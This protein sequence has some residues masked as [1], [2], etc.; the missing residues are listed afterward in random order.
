MNFFIHRLLIFLIFTSLFN[1]KNVGQT[2]NGQNLQKVKLQLKWKHAFQFA[3]YYAAIEKGYYKEAGLDVGLIEADKY[4]EPTKSV[5][6]GQAEFGIGMSD[7]I[8]H[9][10]RGFKPV[11]LASIFQHSPL[12]LITLKNSGIENIHQV[13]GKKLMIELQ[14]AELLAMMQYEGI[15]IKDIQQIKHSFSIQDLIDG[16]VDGMSAYITDEIYSLEKSGIQYNIISPLSSGID[17]YGD[18]LFTTEKMINENP[19]IVLKFTA[20]SLKGWKYALDNKSEIAGLIYSKYSKRL[21]VEH[22]LF[23]ADK[24][25][26]YILPNVVSIGYSN[27][28]RWQ[29]IIEVFNNLGLITNN[30]YVDGLLYDDYTKPKPPVST[31][32][33]IS[34]LITTIIVSLISLIFFRL[35]RKLKSEIKKSKEL[36]GQLKES[37]ELH[38]LLFQTS[39]ESIT[40]VQDNKI[41][42]FN[43]VFPELTGYPS[44]ELINM[45]YIDLIFAEDKQRLREYYER[46]LSGGT[47]P[48][49]YDFRIQQK[50][51]EIR[52]VTIQGANFQWYNKPANIYFLTDITDQKLTHLKLIEL[53][54]NLVRS[55]D[56]LEK[57]N[58]T[59]DKFFS[60]IAHDLRSPFQ[61]FIGLTELLTENLDLYSKDEIV[62]FIN[63]INSKANNLYRLLKN[64]LEWAGMQ[65]GYTEFKPIETDIK[66]IIQEIVTELSPSADK[67]QIVI[68]TNNLKYRKLSLDKNM[69]LSVFRNLISNAIKFTPRGGKVVISGNLEAGNF[70]EITVE[71]TGIGISENDLKKLFKIEEKIS[72]TGTDGEESTGLGLLLSKEFINKHNGSIFVKSILGKGSSFIV[73]LPV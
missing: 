69:I 2:Q 38:K 6:N 68:N 37:E 51:G 59:K 12:V 26:K 31:G 55:K 45:N 36:Y 25:E 56:E 34:L 29:N 17:F 5:F 20:A 58:S 52:W 4:N 10:S 64:L 46:R 24:M 62:S 35:S 32:L 14:N 57:L 8:I 16:S 67:K 13:V 42:Y 33:F 19:D 73:R 53:N 47:V 43:P 18:V 50:T 40:I 27:R 11:I 7:I 39:Q 30:F 1:I 22:L 65:R 49:K 60:I 3:G 54:R 28:S 15:S 63:E 70:V 41:V 72:Q 23:E 48:K 44:S 21:S 66:E 71:D 61:G 9:R